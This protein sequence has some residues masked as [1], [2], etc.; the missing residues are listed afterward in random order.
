[1][2]K[3]ERKSA[4]EAAKKK[5]I[6]SS[7]WGASSTTSSSTTATVE[8]AKEHESAIA[9]VL[10]SAPATVPTLA[11]A[12]H[13]VPILSSIPPS[14]R[15]ATATAS[16]SAADDAKSSTVASGT[17]PATRLPGAAYGYAGDDELWL[18]E[19]VIPYHIPEE[20]FFC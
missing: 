16:V 8:E 17:T 4:D 20:D 15:P 1:M 6:W 19:E 18:D 2:M 13:G 7:L 3:L 12:S 14:Q 5:S 11:S 9:T 10:H